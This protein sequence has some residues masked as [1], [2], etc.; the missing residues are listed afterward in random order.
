[1]SILLLETLHADAEARLSSVDEIVRAEDPN[2]PVVDF[3]KV[4]AILTRGRGRIDSALLHRCP[5]LRVIARAG[6]GLDNLDTVEAARLGIPVIFAP[7]VNAATVAEHTLALMLD[8]TRR[9]SQFAQLVREGLWE[10]RKDYRGDEIG[11]L[12]LGIVGFGNIGR[13]VAE[14]ATAFRMRVLVAEHSERKRIQ[15]SRFETLPME[16]ILR[17]ADILSLHLPLTASTQQIIGPRVFQQMKPGAILINTARGA[18]V[19]MT[20]LRAALE[21]GRLGGFGADVLDVEPPDATDP[22]LRNERVLLTPHV[23]SLTAETYRQICL[24][25]VTHVVRV[26]KGETPDARNVFTIPRPIPHPES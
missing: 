1:M 13:R 3:T 17:R 24:E 4:R 20:A 22:L 11:G 26:L 18:L 9:I 15:D 10:N 12:T 23:A 25:T 8:L 16:E 5:S 19:D 14:L 7:G 2:R 6:A 21:S